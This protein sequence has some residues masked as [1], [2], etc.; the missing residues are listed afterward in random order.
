MAAA[1]GVDRSPRSKQPLGAEFCRRGRLLVMQSPLKRERGLLSFR[2]QGQ[3]LPCS[4]QAG[5]WGVQ[6]LGFSHQAAAP[7]FGEFVDEVDCSVA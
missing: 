4:I 3:G 1:R 5:C 6:V 7:M 2:S